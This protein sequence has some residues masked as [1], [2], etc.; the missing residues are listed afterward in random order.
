MQKRKIRSVFI[1]VLLAAVMLTATVLP[2]SAMQIFVKTLTS[3]TITLEVEPNDSIDAIRAKIQEKE[4][5]PP[6]NQRLIFAGKEL[7]NGKTLSDYNIQKESTLHLVARHACANTTGTGYLS[8][9]EKHW[10]LCE[11]AI[12]EKVVNEE[13]HVYDNACDVSCNVCGAVREVTHTYDNACDASC[14]VCGTA[15]EV[16]H[17]YDSACDTACNVCGG[18]REVP[19]HADADGDRL[20]DGCGIGMEW[21]LSHVQYAILGVAVGLAVGLIALFLFLV[22]RRKQRAGE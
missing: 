20:C 15:R 4:G 2:A 14:N 7:E 5:I 16:A 18:L 9:A 22:R 19:L 8:D 6:E 1:T 10:Q 21:E 11:D 3:K 17:T 13:P 12:C